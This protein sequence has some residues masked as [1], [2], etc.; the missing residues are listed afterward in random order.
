MSIKKS[1]KKVNNSGLRNA[2]FTQNNE[3]EISVTK[4]KIRRDIE[5][6]VST[7]DEYDIYDLVADLANAVNDL[8]EG[9]TTSEAITK[10]KNRQT[11]II[12]IKNQY[13]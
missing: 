7:A 12:N 9:E 4:G 11:S 3:N 2:V 6:N 8:L 10:Y 13:M 1:F 5:R